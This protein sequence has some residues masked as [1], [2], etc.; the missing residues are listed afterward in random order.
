[1][2]SSTLVAQLFMSVSREG[3]PPLYEPLAALLANST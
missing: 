2:I 3:V 1:M